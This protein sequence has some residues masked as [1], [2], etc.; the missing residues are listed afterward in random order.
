VS[1]VSI[2]HGWVP[3]VVGEVVRA[4]AAFYA[5]EWSFGPFFEAKV[6][7]EMGDFLQRYDPA[8]DRL[9]HAEGDGRFLGSLTVDGGDPALAEGVAHL[10]WFIVADGARGRGV[11]GALMRAGLGFLAEAGFRSCYLTTFA[12]LDPARRLYEDAGFVLAG[13]TEAESWGTPVSE[14]RF[15][16][17]LAARR[18]R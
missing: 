2:R 9:F 11:G 13:E 17:D 14:Q 4:H 12:G 6:A 3:G 1:G 10:R 8:K 15:T 16:L 18:Y 5:R 7:R